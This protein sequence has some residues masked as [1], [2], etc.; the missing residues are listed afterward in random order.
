MGLGCKIE[1]KDV[2]V[3]LNGNKILTNV[4]LTFEA[5]KVTTIIGPNGAGKTTLIRLLAGI[6]RPSRGHIRICGFPL[7]NT[8]R[9]RLSSIISYIP[10]TPNFDPWSKVLDVILIGRYGV[11]KG[12]MSSKEDVEAAVKSAS[13]L[14]VTHLLNRYIGSLSSGEL[15]LVSLAMGLARNPRIILADEPLTFLDIRNQLRVIRLLRKLALRGLTIIT[16]SHELHLV[17]LYSDLVVLLKNGKVISSGRPEEVLRR[18][19]ISSAYG[20]DLVYSYEVK[21]PVLLPKIE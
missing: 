20:A 2:E 12:M 6:V 15:K 21:K 10:A 17:P 13:I 1:V 11:M 3:T 5:G 8:Y 9:S 18:E 4:S 14:G 16:T 7:S 19:I